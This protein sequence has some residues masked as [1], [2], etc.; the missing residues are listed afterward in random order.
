MS[1]YRVIIPIGILPPPNQDELYIAQLAAEYFQS[2]ILFVKRFMTSPTPDLYVIKTHQYWEIKT[3]RGNSK[4]TI[5][6][7][8]R[9]ARRQSVNV[10]L[11]IT[12]SKM[13]VSQASGRVQE[14]VQ[15]GRLYAKH[16]LVV[17]KSTKK[18]IDIFP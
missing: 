11:S 9:N 1:N 5:E 8:L 15:H 16:I 17:S 10:I 18:L 2:D 14:C 12:K 13:T 7:A 6:N 3:I 4:R